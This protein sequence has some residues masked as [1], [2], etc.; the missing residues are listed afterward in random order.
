M[1]LKFMN[2]QIKP[3]LFTIAKARTLSLL[4]MLF[5]MVS[6]EERES[7]TKIFVIPEGD[8]YANPRM[9]QSLQSNT[10]DFK[11]VFNETAIYEFEDK[12]FQDSKNKLL[13]FS[14]CN[15][16]H[17]ENS[18]RFAW[19]W[20]NQELEI[21][22]YCYVNGERKERFV[23]TVNLN[24]PNHYRLTLTDSNYIFQLN[25]LE[26]VYIERANICDKGAYYMLWP[27]FGGSLPA[28]HDISL[29]IQM[30]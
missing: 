1:N 19:Q 15:S 25:D 2:Q 16:M 5:F 6:C 8:H 7:L 21:Y 4:T 23:G 28:P 22:A 29:S 13:G 14:D 24:E 12:S 10:L 17:H 18:A 3:D 27:Y 26:P 11:A 30:N 20:Y 9:F